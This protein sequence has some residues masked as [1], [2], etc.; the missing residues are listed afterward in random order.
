M[1]NNRFFTLE[2]EERNRFYQIPKQFMNSESKYFKMGAMTKLIY[3]I[4]S[5]RTKLSIKNGWVN[6]LGQIYFKYSQEELGTILGV[7]D[8]K[9]VRKYLKELEKF[10]LLYRKRLGLNQ[11]DELYLLQIEIEEHLVEQSYQLTGKKSPSKDGKNPVQKVENFPTSDTYQSDTYQSDTSSSS[12]E[13]IDEEDSKLKDLENKEKETTKEVKKRLINELQEKILENK[14][15]CSKY[16]SASGWDVEIAESGFNLSTEEI[17]IKDKKGQKI[18]NFIAYT[19]KV[20][21]NLRKEMN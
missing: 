16:L 13:A 4:F 7:K 14:A 2:T 6:D 17:G 11:S 12:K 20:I 15:V 3:G 1:S 21:K 18:Y 9:T 5:D 10:D 8:T 19:I